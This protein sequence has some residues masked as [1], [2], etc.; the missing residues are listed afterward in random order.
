MKDFLYPKRKSYASGFFKTK[1]GCKLYYERYGN[2]KSPEKVVYLHGGPGAGC[3]FDEYRYFNP[4]HYDVLI[5]DQ[6][7][8]GKSRPVAG[9]RHNSI[10]AAIA[11]LEGLR[12]HFGFKKW[13]IAGG[14]W[15]SALALL[16]TVRHPA[17]VKSLLLRGV[18]FGDRK[19]A[20]Y[21]IEKDGAA[22][23]AKGPW[24]EEYRRFANKKS[25][26]RPYY[27]LLMQKGPRAAEAARLFM[28]WDTAIATAKPDKALIESVNAAP[29]RNM[30]LSRTFFHF[31]VHE[32][33]NTHKSAILKAVKKLDIPIH[34]VHGSH[35]HICPVKNAVLLSKYCKDGHLQV[36][37]NGG[38][39]L[40]DPKI[41]RAFTRAA[42]EIAEAF[43]V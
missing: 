16:Y 17:K 23:K 26:L 37:K 31:S 22:A 19:G 6:R 8:S 27:G 20:R 25:L 10:K 24:F 18:F 15:G 43:K 11:D 32:F 33:K 29:F 9:E 1:G 28:R 3:A 21:I 42:D 41:G 13:H 35:D 34:I 14:S 12:K 40:R 36:V 4:T 7:W 38:H 2:P 5:F 30:A 39:T